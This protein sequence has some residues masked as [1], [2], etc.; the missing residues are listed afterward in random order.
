METNVFMQWPLV[1]ILFI[2]F[3]VF[4]SLFL[5]F[6]GLVHRVGSKSRFKGSVHKV[7]SMGQFKG[8]FHG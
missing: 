4:F 2:F 8:S 7:G 6:L 3:H 1:Q 5:F